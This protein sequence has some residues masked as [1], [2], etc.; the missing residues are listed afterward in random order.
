MRRKVM[1]ACLA[2]MIAVFSLAFAEAET[3]RG[4]LEERFADI[5]RI[6][7]EGNVYRMKNR[8]TTVLAMGAANAPDGTLCAEVSFLLVVDD[9]AKTFNIVEIPSDTLVAMPI[10]DG[11]TWNM[12]FGTVCSMGT[13]ADEGA[14]KMLQAA[15]ILLGEEL[16]Q[17]YMAFDAAGAVTVD[18][19]LGEIEDVRERLKAMGALIQEMDSDQYNA[20]YQQLGD[21][22]TTDMKSGAAVKI[23]DKYDRYEVLPRS[24]LPGYAA[25]AND[26]GTLYVPDADAIYG[27]VVDNFY[28]AENH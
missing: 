22:I 19:A 10:G 25:A 21:Y 7:Y 5:P 12:R 23:I 1:A 14:Q 13:G 2:L 11:K 9:D 24:S 28:E 3:V 16:V 27:F 8:V 15:N 17:H 26:G 4:N 6:E 20:V 18:P